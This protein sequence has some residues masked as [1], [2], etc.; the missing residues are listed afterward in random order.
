[1]TKNSLVGKKFLLVTAAAVLGFG[2]AASFI[3]PS[4]NAA[5]STTT[6]VTTVAPVVPADGGIEGPS[7]ES[8]APEA[9]GVDCNNGLDASGAQC[10]GG[11][12]ANAQDATAESLGTDENQSEVSGGTD[13][14]NIQSQN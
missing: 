13:G 10:D 6:A 1:M 9:A 11:P 12:A 2:V 3:V 8:T 5:P 7:S 4:A 14:D